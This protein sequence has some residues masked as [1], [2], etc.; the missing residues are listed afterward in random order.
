MQK[1]MG[2]KKW[3]FLIGAVFIA[4]LI[5]GDVVPRLLG[6]N[7][8]APYLLSNLNESRN[9]VEI[10]SPDNT[11]IITTYNVY[12]GA[13]MT[14]KTMVLARLK[15]ERF[16]IKRDAVILALE[17]IRRVNISW[18]SNRQVEIQ[19]GPG[20]IY[21]ALTKWKDVGIKYSEK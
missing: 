4:V 20:V 19:Y 21:T 15:S 17:G 1:K 14:D 13:T 12:G 16:L 2:F 11:I 10:P 8:F 6:V 18:S 3:M 7:F 9:F 5:L